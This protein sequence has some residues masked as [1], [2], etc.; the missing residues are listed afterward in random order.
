MWY[1]YSISENKN[2][3]FDDL[4]KRLEFKA[5]IRSDKELNE[6]ESTLSSNLSL[7]DIIQKISVDVMNYINHNYNPPEAS[8]KQMSNE[9]KTK[10]LLDGAQQAALNSV[11]ILRSFDETLPENL[12]NLVNQ[13]FEITKKFPGLKM[14][15]FKYSK[16]LQWD[17]WQV[18]RYIL[19]GTI[20][21][22]IKSFPGKDS[23]KTFPEYETQEMRGT[24]WWQKDLYGRY[25]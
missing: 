1:R 2:D 5:K 3:E 6:M 8:E 4:W 7:S 11:L 25:I 14:S 10:I 16:D 24:Y 18:F 13:A 19:Q 15:L 23:G 17:F 9:Q 21:K 12:E 20:K 22:N